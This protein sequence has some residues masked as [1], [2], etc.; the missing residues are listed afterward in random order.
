MNKII[1]SIPAYEDDLLIY[2][3]NSLYEKAALPNN[4]FVYVALQ[5]KKVPDLSKVKS[6]NHITY[7]NYDVERRPGVV[8]VRYE[9]G[10]EILKNTMFDENDYYLMI[11]AHMDFTQNWD[12]DL[13]TDLNKLQKEKN[14]KEILFS[15]IDSVGLPGQLTRNLWKRMVLTSSLQNTFNS[16]SIYYNSFTAL[17]EHVDEFTDKFELHYYTCCHFIFAPYNFLTDVGLDPLTH[18]FHEE[19]YLSFK[20]FM[21]GWDVYANL[22]YNYIA[23][24]GIKQHNPK[25]KDLRYWRKREDGNYGRIYSSI[26]NQDP[27]YCSL[28]LLSF[29]N[30]TGPYAIKNAKRSAKDF[31]IFNNIEH[32]YDNLINNNI[33]LNYLSELEQNTILD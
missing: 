8:R 15:K 24:I 1:V 12:L 14:K 27:E 11:D 7:L 28:M 25:K 23:H 19:P 13:I 21:S 26:F 29:I 3:L 10:Q 17:C 32:I 9:I 30:N 4:I 18:I 33:L 16:N 5:Y 20:T 22:S 6:N 2:T 31:F